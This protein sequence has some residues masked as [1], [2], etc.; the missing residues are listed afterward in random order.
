L[1]DAIQPRCPKRYSV[2][3]HGGC[4]TQCVLA[5]GHEPRECQLNL[6]WAVK[7]PPLEINI[8]TGIDPTPFTIRREA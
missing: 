6:W 7:V 2:G 8:G 4:S 1:N 3:H 5:A